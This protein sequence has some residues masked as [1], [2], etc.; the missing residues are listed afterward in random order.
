MTAELWPGS[1]DLDEGLTDKITWFHAAPPEGFSSGKSQARPFWSALEALAW[2]VSGRNSFV[3]HIGS[4]E[5]SD[6]GLPLGPVPAL[7]Q[8]LLLTS[9]WFCE[10]GSQDTPRYVDEDGDFHGP[11]TF[12]RDCS[13][14]E[15][16][17]R[18]LFDAIY[19]G[20]V[21]A[22]DG[23]TRALRQASDFLDLDHRNSATDWLRLGWSPKFSSR[24]IAAAFSGPLPSK[25]IFNDSDE[26]EKACEPWLIAAFENP[27]NAKK[28]K[29]I[30]QKEA[31]ATHTGLSVRGFGRVWSKLAPKFDRSSPG[32]KK[33]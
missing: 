22:F 32:R 29:G 18:R 28:A 11:E 12:W 13:C 5:R 23:E 19:A 25:D 16:A 33:S 8:L 31:L 2:I 1:S 14:V 4:I 7:G 27:A 24:A 30:F 20:D 6:L 26:A 17:G 3:D 21:Q 10:C 9:I 15:N